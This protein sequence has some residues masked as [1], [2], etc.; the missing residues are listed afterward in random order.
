MALIPMTKRT[1]R[2]Q[3]CRFSAIS[4]Q[5]CP[6]GETTPATKPRVAAVPGPVRHTAHPGTTGPGRT[7]LESARAAP[8]N[9]PFFPRSTG[10]IIVE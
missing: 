6:N 8:R 7:L 4:A 10:L 3:K 2:P 1:K 5:K 9:D